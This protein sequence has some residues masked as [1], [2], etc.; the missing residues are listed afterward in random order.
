MTEI[1]VQ[2]QDV[3]FFVLFLSKSVALPEDPVLGK[4]IRMF[5]TKAVA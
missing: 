1:A 2:A 3:H 5:F 4:K